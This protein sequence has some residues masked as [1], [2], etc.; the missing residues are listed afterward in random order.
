[1]AV[2][3]GLMELPDQRADSLPIALLDRLN[4]SAGLLE[5]CGVSL[6]IPASFPPHL[7]CLAVQLLSLMQGR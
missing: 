5:E 3:L 6:L 7:L 4:Q 1:M 2:F